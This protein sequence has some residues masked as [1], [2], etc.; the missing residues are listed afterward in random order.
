MRDTL[1]Q[2]P[3]AGENLSFKRS[4]EDEGEKRRNGCFLSAYLCQAL[5]ICPSVNFVCVRV[6]HMCMLSHFRCV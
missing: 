3:G 4:R 2:D 1:S 5:E 6:V